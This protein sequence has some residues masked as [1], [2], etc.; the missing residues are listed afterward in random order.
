MPEID[1][2]LAILPLVLAMGGWVARVER[3]TK[4]IDKINRKLN[5]IILHLAGHTPLDVSKVLNGEGSQNS[6]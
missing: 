4:D 1:P 2:L 6:Q 5:H 3:K